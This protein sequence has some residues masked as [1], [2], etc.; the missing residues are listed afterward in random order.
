MEL[1]TNIY[2]S[3]NVLHLFLFCRCADKSQCIQRSWVCDG[4]A[5]CADRSDEP[6]TCE[7]KPCQ[8]GDF[9]CKNKRCVPVKFRCDYYDDC[10]E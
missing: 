2:T 1:I 9:R 8:A 7:F 3:R 4:T 6:E 5:D 10:G